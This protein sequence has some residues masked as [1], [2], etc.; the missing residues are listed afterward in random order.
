M[1]VCM[2]TARGAYRTAEG[3][4]VLLPERSALWT[5]KSA[6]IT[7]VV[8]S[9]PGIVPVL[10]PDGRAGGWYSYIDNGEE[11]FVVIEQA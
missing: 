6:L 8:L 11:R 10:S 4:I 7:E 5:D 9:H 3:E 2:W 1:G